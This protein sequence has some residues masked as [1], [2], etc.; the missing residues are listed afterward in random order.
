MK[1]LGMYISTNRVVYW[2]GL[3]SNLVTNL[4]FEIILVGP[5]KSNKLPTLPEN[6]KFIYSTECP[7]K[8]FHIG[9]MA[10]D[11]EYIMNFSDDC[12]FEKDFA[13]DA[14]IA[15]IKTRPFMSIGSPRYP[16]YKS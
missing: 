10:C 2:E 14:L 11:S 7:A 16:R 13:L 9:A 1:T 15:D 6:A 5:I 12:R 8:C 3:F 4:D